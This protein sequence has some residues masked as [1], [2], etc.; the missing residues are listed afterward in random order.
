[1]VVFAL[2]VAG[3]F[4]WLDVEWDSWVLVLSAQLSPANQRS[5]TI[6]REPR[7]D[8]PDLGIGRATESL[9]PRDLF[10]HAWDWRGVTLLTRK[11][12]PW[13]KRSRDAGRAIANRGRGANRL[14]CLTAPWPLRR[15][16]LG[17]GGPHRQIG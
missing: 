8:D 3:V 2:I 4:T 13:A 6:E 16:G 12:C 14:S 10:P 11:L 17:A 5:R 7:S 15:S 9:A 1:M